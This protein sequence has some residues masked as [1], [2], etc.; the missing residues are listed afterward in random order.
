MPRVS[1]V[2]FVRSAAVVVALSVSAAAGDPSAAKV[3]PVT[4]R[5]TVVE[6]TAALKSLGLKYDTEPVA[7]QVV[8]KA[9]DGTLTPL[10]SDDASRALFEDVRLRGRRTEIQGRRHPGIPYLQVVTFQIEDEGRLRTPE[11]FCE[12]CTI[13]VRFPQICPCCQ[14]EMVLRMRPEHD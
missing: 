9:D 8:L 6:L 1:A 4:L 7:R 10:F 12:V 2:W 5:G 3:E 14:G 13:S 11:Y